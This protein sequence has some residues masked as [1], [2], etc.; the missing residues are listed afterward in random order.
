[1]TT[2]QCSMP[3]DSVAL[4]RRR[5]PSQGRAQLT[6][7]SIVQAAQQL[8]DED[9]PQALTTRRI[10]ERAGVSIG[11]L[12][13]YF[14]NREA[15]VVQLFEPLLQAAAQ[16]GS[17]R[18]ESGLATED[19]FVEAY[20]GQIELVKQLV[21]IDELTFASH[22]KYLMWDWV[23]ERLGMSPQRRCRNIQRFLSDRLPERNPGEVEVAS[24]LLGIGVPSM[25][26]SLALESPRLLDEHSLHDKLADIIQCA[27]R[28]NTQSV[29]GRGKLLGGASGRDISR[30][31]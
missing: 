9:G 13:Q 23:S 15:I 5:I 7:N 12:Y 16:R 30:G 14:P 21:D 18:Y 10:A 19:F 29:R 24:F 26:D 31:P 28:A 22:Q 17:L 25:I 1:M 11:S 6:V 8:L 4:Q 3:A 20:R 2:K 27:L